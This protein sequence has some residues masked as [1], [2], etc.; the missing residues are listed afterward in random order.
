MGYKGVMLRLITFAILA[1]LLLIDEGEGREVLSLGESG[2]GIGG[3]YQ[4][5]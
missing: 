3:V 5:Q 1:L 2:I 4:R